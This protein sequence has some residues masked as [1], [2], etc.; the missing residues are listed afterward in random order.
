MTDP[1]AS[2]HRFD[3][4]VYYEDTDFSARV[5]HASYLRFLERARTEL[6]REA[7]IHQGALHQSE[8]PYFFVVRRMEIEWLKPA[9]MDD[10]LCV[11]TQVASQ[12]GPLLTLSQHIL[13]D[14]QLLLTAEVLVVTIKDNKPARLPEALAQ[15]FAAYGRAVSST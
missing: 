13:R 4:R 3:L 15:R 14:D 5:Y 10:L 9:L 6:L 1:A 11:H 2:V 12:R 8:D 7:G